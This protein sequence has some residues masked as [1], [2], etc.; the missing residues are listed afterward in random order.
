[1]AKYTQEIKDKAVELVKQ[2]V[3]FAEI[4]RTLGPNPK[5]VQRYLKKAGIEMPKKERVA[6]AP[7][8]EKTPAVGNKGK[9]PKVSTTYN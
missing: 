5:A 2:G 1:M 8:T 9:A 4:Q 6:K 3:N 7:K